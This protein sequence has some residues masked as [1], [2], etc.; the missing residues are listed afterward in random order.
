ME[1][2]PRGG[3][4]DAHG[5]GPCGRKSLGVRVPPRAPRE[6][7][8]ENNLDTIE[9]D[10]KKKRERSASWRKEIKKSGRSVFK[11]QEIIKKK[12][13]QN[14]DDNQQNNRQGI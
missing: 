13:K 14:T 8:D 4:V 1:N 10:L 12:T 11:L 2:S 7:M 9:E 5:L 3:T 6:N